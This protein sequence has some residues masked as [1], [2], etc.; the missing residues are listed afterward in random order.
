M[1]AAMAKRREWQEEF[2][3]AERVLADAGG[4][5]VW[6]SDDYVAFRFIGEGVRIVFYPH[7]TSARNYHLRVR[8][9]ACKNK[10]LADELMLQLDIGAGHD[11]TFSRKNSGSINTVL[12]YAREN[13]LTF[14][15]ARQ[16]NGS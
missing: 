6:A 7:R 9:E 3:I 5:L 10:S 2:D 12:D 11:C 15:W 4:E 8:T 1:G 16:Q 13:D 14:G